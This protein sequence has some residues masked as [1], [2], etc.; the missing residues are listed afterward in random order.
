MFKKLFT[1]HYK[2]QA[3]VTV[4]EI[5]IATAVIGII[6]STLGGTLMY[7][8]RNSEFGGER[9][10]AAM[11]ANEG[12]EATRNIRDEDFTNLVDGTYGL[13]VSSNQW[14]FSGSQ[15]IS[16]GF[17]RETTISSVDASTKEVTTSVA[18]DES[19]NRP[20]SVSVTTRFNNW[21]LVVKP[22]CDWTIGIGQVSTYDLSDNK[23]GLKIQAEGDY[24]YMV[25][26]DG[27]PDFII[28]NVSNIAGPTIEGSLDLSDKP[29]N[30]AISGNYAYVSS[31]HNSQELQVINISNPA[32][33]SVVG[34]YDA[35]K[36]SD[37]EGIYIEDSYAYLVKKSS[38]KEEL[39]IIDI[40]TPSSPSLMGSLDLGD[41]AY[42][43]VVIG[44]YAYV[45]S[46]DNNQELQ[47]I[48]I[49]TP[50]SPSQVGSYNL[51]GN[52]DA[53][54]VTGF[55]STVILGRKSGGVHVF[56]IPP[57]LHPLRLAGM[58]QVHK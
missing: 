19:S 17:T 18:W 8:I 14:T 55:D 9:E 5:V 24:A 10:R 47:V 51:S 53:L 57:L 43:V 4:V 30:I 38:N 31:K 39:F 15:D 54:T 11:L 35:D 58:M 7:G 49:S 36:N 26:D 32:S 12:I 1:T 37:A 25:R 3:G 33:P 13:A 52:D 2:L 27:S 21:G 45:A 28:F 50:A 44:N 6:F 22:S 20:G 23:K 41:S 46:K 42:E 40:S 16:N 34:T 29:I 56:D 48:D